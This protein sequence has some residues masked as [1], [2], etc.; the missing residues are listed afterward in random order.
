M[1]SRAGEL[2]LWASLHFC[3]YRFQEHANRIRYYKAVLHSELIS[4]GVCCGTE[5]LAKSA[6]SRS[7]NSLWDSTASSLSLL[8]AIPF[9]IPNPSPF[10]VALSPEDPLGMDTLD[11]T[12]IPSCLGVVDVALSW[13]VMPWTGCVSS[14]CFISE[15]T[16]SWW[17]CKVRSKVC[18]RP[19]WFLKLDIFLL[20]CSPPNLLSLY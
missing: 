14:T 10:H 2:H 17:F 4:E 19:V 16:F 6:D 13:V 9:A 20:C 11:H 12:Q 8:S 1:G 5:F 7:T 18:L 3:S 15:N